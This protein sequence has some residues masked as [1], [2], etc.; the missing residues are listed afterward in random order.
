MKIPSPAAAA[1]ALASLTLSCRNAYYGAMESMGIHKRDMLVERV[2]EARDEQEAAKEEFQDAL[3]SFKNITGFSGGDLE[4]LYDRLSDEYE[5]CADQAEEV[6]DR[7][8]A[9][10][11]VSKDL[12]SEWRDELS[13]YKD[14]EL[15]QESEKQLAVTKKR[16]SDLIAAMR[17]AEQ[18]M[19][20]VLS[21]FHDRVLFLKHNLNA[22]A[23]ASLQGQV[24]QLEGDVETL[25]QKMEAAI[26]EA[27]AF[28]DTLPEPQSQS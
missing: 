12:I 1:L 18:A 22:Q 13:E 17:R 19:H 2:E 21:A 11:Q 9:V 26:Q 27:N 20:P 28:I 15:R 3:A 6:D 5:D 10:E 8:D 25:I 16:C 14:A 24:V 7:I 4:K 23:I